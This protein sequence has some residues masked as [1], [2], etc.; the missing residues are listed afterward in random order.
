MPSPSTDVWYTRCPVPTAFSVALANGWIDDELA[1]DGIGVHSLAVSGDANVR[2]SHF[3]QQ[4][5]NLFRHG[6]NVPPL[7][8]RSRGA[9]V[10]LI[11]LSWSDFYEPVLVLPDSG[12]E[13]VADLRGRRIS[14]PRRVNEPVDFWWAT[15]LHGYARALSLAG[16]TLDDVEHV[17]I[18]VDRT[19]YD[20]PGSTV[21]RASLSSALELIGHHREEGLALLTGKVDA[22]FSHAS[23]APGLQ[24]FTGAVPLVDVGALPDRRLRINNGIPLAFTVTGDLLDARPDIVARVLAQTIRAGEWAVEN[25]VPTRQI[26]ASDVGLA[27][28]LVSLSYSDD[29]ARQLDVD[30]S[31]ERL[32]GL[33]SQAAWLHERGFLAEPVDVEAFVD[34]APLQEALRLLGR[35]QPAGV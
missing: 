4:Q 29:V 28:E 32:E 12:I 20:R 16:L 3:T 13:T 2:R 17:D 25:P 19:Y 30:L 31:A 18:P 10:R 1:A 33:A 35:E 7:V 6:G 11:G 34:P 24:G 21:P 27:D 8:A 26:V 15:S 23:L 14:V 5:A 9:D 22:V